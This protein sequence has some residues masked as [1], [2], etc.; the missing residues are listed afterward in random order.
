VERY[1]NS[2]DAVL[3]LHGFGT[4]S[5]LWRGVAPSL[6]AAGY[7]A[8]A[9][10]MLGY[11][12]SDRP[13]EADYSIAAQ[14]VY[15][16]RALTSLRVQR[17]AVVGVD[18]G[19]GVA[20]RLAVTKKNGVQV[21]HLALINSVG[22]EQCPGREVRNVQ[23]DTARFAFHVSRGVLGAAPLMRRLLVASVA[24]QKHMPERLLAR[25]MAPFAGSDGVTH[26]LVLARAL[27][28]E[29]VED[30][31]LGTIAAPTLIIWGE[32]D[33]WLDSGLAE[34][35]QGAIPQSRVIRL[36]GVA[37]LVPE[38]ASET[39]SELLLEFLRT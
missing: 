28:A 35:L 20:Q 36:P 31:E 23:R 33:A 22:L 17:A 37:R 10:D 26:L 25:Y 4:T 39:L 18:I 19:G 38:E 11:G 27:Q 3:L 9:M 24:D 5:F 32:A 29:D 15:V 8:Y 16:E 2:G 12:E 14:A 6:A 13:L 21:S 30:L 34:R 7:T 1:G